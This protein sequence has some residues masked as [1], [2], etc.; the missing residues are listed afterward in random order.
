MAVTNISESVILVLTA[1]MIFINMKVHSLLKCK[2]FMVYVQT[3][4]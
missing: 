3:N 4:K 1:K 2:Q